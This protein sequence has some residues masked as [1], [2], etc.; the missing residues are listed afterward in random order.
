M[1]AKSHSLH[2]YGTLTENFACQIPSIRRNRR[3]GSLSLSLIS[4]LWLCQNNCKLLVQ[5]LPMLWP[6]GTKTMKLWVHMR[7]RKLKQF[8]CEAYDL[9]GAKLQAELEKES[10]WKLIERFA[11]DVIYE[12]LGATLMACFSFCFNWYF[13]LMAYF[14]LRRSKNDFSHKDAS[15]F[16]P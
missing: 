8:I 13:S 7:Q 9:E 12:A 15:L 6:K 4:E 11:R 1:S 5:S 10:E 2:D 14:T 3:R 16:M